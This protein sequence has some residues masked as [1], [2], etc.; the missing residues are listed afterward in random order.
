MR[1]HRPLAARIIRRILVVATAVA[2]GPA[3]A[4]GA[5][6]AQATVHPAATY[7]YTVNSTADSHDAN[8]GNG[9]CADSQGRCTLRAAIEAASADPSGSTITITVPAGTY[10][11]TLGTLTES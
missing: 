3:L 6:P 10:A 4:L 1:V 9:I 11:L 2:T 5:A 8:P 7:S